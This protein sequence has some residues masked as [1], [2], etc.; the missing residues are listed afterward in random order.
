M[1]LADAFEEFHERIQLAPLSENRINSAWGRLHE[2]LTEK[3]ELS[4]EFVFIQ[5]SYANGTAVKPADSDGEYDLDIVAVC[6]DAHTTAETAIRNLTDVLSENKDLAER[7]EPNQTGRPCVR[8]RYAREESGFGFHVDV[9]PARHGQLGAPLDVPVRG[10]EDWRATDPLRYTRWCLET[11]PEQFR[12]NVRFLKRWRD[13]H[14]DGGI[15]SI[16]LQVL[17]AAHT[18]TH[19]QDDA[20]RV[21]AVLDGIQQRLAAFPSS[22]PAINNPVLPDENLADRWDDQDY[23]AFLRELAEALDLAQQALTSNDAE[24][25]HGLWQ[26]LFG[27]A[28]PAAPTQPSARPKIPPVIPPPPDHPQPQ[29]APRERYGRSAPPLV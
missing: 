1:R 11:Q 19:I 10:Y 22:P 17:V 7:I 16:V 2:Y 13:V 9:T 20:E 21:V 29:R 6:V 25:S 15:A 28:F 24:E 18:P 4:D 5:G 8:L 3:Y 26:K 23:Q 14:H 12:R 27:A